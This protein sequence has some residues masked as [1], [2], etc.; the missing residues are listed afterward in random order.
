MGNAMQQPKPRGFGLYSRVVYVHQAF[1]LALIV[2]AL[3]SHLAR[4]FDAV[5]FAHLVGIVISI[6]TLLLMFA[7]STRKSVKALSWLR[8]ILWIGVFRILIVQVW[9]LAHGETQW[10]TTVRDIVLN[11]LVSI[12]MALF[13]SRPVLARYLAALQSPAASMAH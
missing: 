9:L 5:M 10:A 6:A 11:E 1:S 13:W 7:V 8:L 12:P 3:S 4:G 2:A